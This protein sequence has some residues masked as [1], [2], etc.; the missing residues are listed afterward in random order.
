MYTAETSCTYYTVPDVFNYI[1]CK[2]PDTEEKS[3]VSEALE[4]LLN[5]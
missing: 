5:E 1:D 4:E 2:S 3:G